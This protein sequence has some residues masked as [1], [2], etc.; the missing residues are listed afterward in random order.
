MGDAV[1]NVAS[2]QALGDDAQYPLKVEDAKK[3][4]EVVIVTQAPAQQSTATIEIVV[5]DDKQQKQTFTAQYKPLGLKFR[6]SV[7][8]VITDYKEP[9]YGKELGIPKGVTLESMNGVALP[10][11]FEQAMKVMQQ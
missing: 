6:K 7:P 2:V 10:N 9:S 4:E 11:D 1:E 3:P 5:V 8:I